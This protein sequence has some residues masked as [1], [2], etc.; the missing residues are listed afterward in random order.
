MDA[1]QVIQWLA[2][3]LAVLKSAA[4]FF[5]DR[6][7]ADY[8]RERAGKM[9]PVFEGMIDE[10]TY[11]RSVDYT[12]AKNRL[13]QFS[14]PCGLIILLA[15]LF[16]GFLPWSYDVFLDFAGESAWAKAAWIIG[17]IFLFSATEWP[18]EWYRQFR[19][20]ERFGFNKTT[21][22]LWIVDRIKG[23]VLAVLLGVP[24]LALLLWLVEAVGSHWWFYGWGTAISFQIAMMFV[25][26]KWI[27][28]WFNRFETLAEGE[29]RERLLRLGKAANFSASTIQVMDGSK[30]SAHSNAFFAGFGRSRKI[31]LFDTLLQ[32]LSAA[33][34]EAVLA[35]EIGHY[36]KKHVWKLLAWSCFA[37]LVGFWMLAQLMNFPP[38][39]A[40]F[41]FAEGRLAPAFL[42]FGLLSGLIS[43]WI[44]PLSSAWSRKFEYEADAFASQTIDS[45]NASS[46]AGA[47]T[48]INALR[49]LAEKN[50]SNLTPHPLYSRFYY[51]HPTLIE[52][53]QAL[54]KAIPK[55]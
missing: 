38:F 29:L 7:N 10:E 35:H 55:S 26:P 23:A 46:G 30:R 54:Q 43:F 32:Q 40:A 28:P 21:L 18:W 52:R 17:I 36:K 50:L 13:G 22:R 27:L 37:L 16:S 42:L 9:P 48:L 11:N 5:L 20:E 15:A 14:N 25:V 53:E 31:V 1:I 45:E 8:V 33:E 39:L 24:M 3:G 41:G 6:L 51:S 2:A 4:E 49:K 19:L 47:A 34:L 44:T 12:L